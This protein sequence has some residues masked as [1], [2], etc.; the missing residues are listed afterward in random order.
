M[1][2]RKNSEA[3]N[4]KEV[5]YGRKSGQDNTSEN[6]IENRPEKRVKNKGGNKTGEFIARK[7]KERGMTQKEMAEL[8]GVTNK[9]V[10]KWETS[11]GMPDIGILPE[12]GK[13]LGVTVDEILMGEQIEQEK[14]AETA[15]SDEDKKLLEIVLER[16]ERCF[17]LS[18]NLVCGGVDHSADLDSDSGKRTW[19]DLY[20]ECNSICDKR[21]GSF[22]FLGRRH[23][24]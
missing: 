15:V 8:L 21:G 11:Q 2:E 9:A 19:I 3:G 17:W 4:E 7:R 24:H 16:A 10:S 18:A 12:L 14:R 23:V 22:P 13:A 5:D 20:K 1:Q 6:V